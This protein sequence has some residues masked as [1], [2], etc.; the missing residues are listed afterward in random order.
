M[1]PVADALTR[2][3]SVFSAELSETRAVLAKPQ[4]RRRKEVRYDRKG[5]I[6]DVIEHEVED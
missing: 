3:S 4:P 6:T 2:M 5:H 1:Q